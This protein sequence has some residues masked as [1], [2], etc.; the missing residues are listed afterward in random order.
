MTPNPLLYF[1]NLLVSLF[2]AEELDMF[3]HLYIGQG[4]LPTGAPSLEV[5]AFRAACAIEQR[6]FLQKEMFWRILVT[7]RPGREED[8]R[9]VE[10]RFRTPP[11]LFLESPIKAPP[12]ANLYIDLDPVIGSIKINF[13]DVEVWEL[14][15]SCALEVAQR[16]GITLEEVGEILNLTRKRIRQLE[17]PSWKH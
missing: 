1:R 15:H 2:Q 17:A 6:G 12:L 5:L 16:G 4:L 14:Q 10:R 13:A 7:E 11:P 8:I 3:V 9:K